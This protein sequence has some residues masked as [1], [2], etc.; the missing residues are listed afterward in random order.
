[1][2][3]KDE[4]IQSKKCSP[5]WSAGLSLEALAT[6]IATIALFGF[7][8]QIVWGQAKSQDHSRSN[9]FVEKIEMRTCSDVKKD[10]TSS[11]SKTLKDVENMDSRS[12]VSV[13]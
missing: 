6:I 9:S 8:Y 13:K 4:I 12:L 2:L 7:P 1:M 11:S 3:M 10:D 5:F